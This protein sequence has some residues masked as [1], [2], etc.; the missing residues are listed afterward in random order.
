MSKP[1]LNQEMLNRLPRE[2]DVISYHV[3]IDTAGRYIILK[4]RTAD[5]RFETVLM[6]AVVAI[7]IRDSLRHTDASLESDDQ[8]EQ[9]FLK[10]QPEMADSDWSASSEHVE[11]AE[12]CEVHEFSGA[13]F[14][15]FLTDKSRQI[16]KV[17]RL[18]K[19]IAHYFVGYVD[20]AERS[21]ALV[22]LKKA[23]PSSDKKH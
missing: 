2:R 18:N 19:S 1:K 22:N 12:G 14:L 8:F 4:V 23:R 21:G 3:G 17:L 7:H 16:Y 5:E 10:M 20:D 9:R 13:I 15:G 6:P 11:T